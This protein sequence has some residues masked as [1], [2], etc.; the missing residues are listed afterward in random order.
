MTLTPT[1][2]E[3]TLVVIEEDVDL[4]KTAPDMDTTL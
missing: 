2:V 1:A 3:L 4:D